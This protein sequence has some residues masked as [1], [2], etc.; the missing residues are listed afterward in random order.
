MLRH[1][2]AIL[3]CCACA[4]DGR[5]LKPLTVAA[6]DGTEV[7]R[8]TSHHALI[9]GNSRYTAGWQ[10]LPGVA[11]DVAAVQ[12]ALE[13][14]GFAVQ[15]A[16][17]LTRAQMDE[18]I[19]AF[20]AERGQDPA[21]R[22]VV[23]YAGHG[24]TIRNPQGGQET[25]YLVPVDAPVP[26]EGNRPAFIAKS[27]PIQRIKIAAQEIG[28][29]HALFVFDACF[30]GSLFAPLRGGGAAV[31]R[32]AAEPVRMFITSGSSDEQVPDHSVFR[33]EF[34]AALD[35]GVADANRDGWTTGSEL[36]LHLRQ[37]V[38]SRRAAAGGTQTPQ[39][40]ISEQSG[41]N[42]G[43]V[44]FAARPSDGASIYERLSLRPAK[45]SNASAKT[46]EPEPAQAPAAES[47]PKPGW[48]VAA[49]SDEF[50][51]WADLAV[52]NTTQRLR[53]VRGGGGVGDLW[54]LEA[55]C[56]QRLWSAVMGAN[57]SGWTGQT[58]LKEL[59]LGGEAPEPS[60][61]LPVETVS[62]DDAQAFLAKLN[63]SVPELRARLPTE[64]EWQWA[65]T[66]GS[67][68][69]E[70]VVAGA[71]VRSTA[72]NP[73]PASTAVPN[74]AGLRDMLGN[75]WEWCADPWNEAPR[76]DP[77]LERALRLGRNRDDLGAADRRA[78]RGGGFLD[79]AATAESRLGEAAGYRSR[80]IGFRFVIDP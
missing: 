50:G 10:P 64:A 18:T 32:Q 8:F 56:S 27:F 52:G 19:T 69:P 11:E 55:E 38:A 4:E 12:G 17:D 80:D 45:P 21:G 13:R 48:V 20:V 66:L 54:V 62:W 71:R 61:L 3:A 14:H 37:Q 31:L 30:S 35:E 53:L 59:M 75:V 26:G 49:G 78:L 9:I 79:K 67:A 51:A 73:Q 43:D 25:G 72:R 42:K 74:P 34:V 41:M 47:G 68:V 24:Q 28:A 16:R 7:A 57:P 6:A 15:V 58:R 33:E 70:A 63:A 23:Y 39:A 76:R 1:I 46:S 65:A 36:S 40:G 5:G 77:A 22:V 29:R 60:G 44:V 2:L